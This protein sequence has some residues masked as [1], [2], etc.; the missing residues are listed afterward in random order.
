VIYRFEDTTLDAGRRE[1]YRAGMLC[2][3]EPQTFD[4][5]EYLICNRHRLVTRKDVLKAVWHGRIVSEAALDTRINAVRRA[6]GDHG[7]DQRLIKTIRTK[8]YRFVG[9]VHEEEEES[10][11]V[12]RLFGK[13]IEPAASGK[14]RIGIIPFKP[15]AADQD[16]ALFAQALEEDLITVLLHSSLGVCQ[17]PNADERNA[18][19]L[20]RIAQESAVQYLIS[21]TVRKT[22]EMLRATAQF[23]EGAT[24]THLWAERYG[25]S[26][27]ELTTLQDVIAEKIGTGVSGILCHNRGNGIWPRQLERRQLTIISGE[28]VDL[29]KLATRS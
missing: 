6:I 19:D 26:I 14:A 25:V 24:G 10:D 11:R 29:A 23:I 18:P 28:F 15:I 17:L 16:C 12:P 5:L 13:N 1:L 8:G 2:P 4:L 21:G 7:N 22:G 3:L 20:R 27:A 9:Q